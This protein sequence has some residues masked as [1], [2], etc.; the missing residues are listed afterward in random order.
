MTMRRSRRLPIVLVVVSLALLVAALPP[1]PAHAG[2]IKAVA[3]KTGLN[4]PAAFTF[5]PGGLIF[6]GEK[7][8]GQI[9]VLNRT[10]KATRLF[11]QVPNIDGAG[12][13]G[14]LGIALHPKWPRAPFLYAYVTRTLSTGTFNQIIRLRS[15]HGH[16]TRMKVLFQ[17]RLNT[18]TNHNGGRILFGPDRMLY[19]VVGEN[20]VPA[21]SQNRATPL[22]KVLRMNTSG[23][24][25]PGNPFHNRVFS[26]GLRNSFGFDF[27]PLT[28]R[29]WESENGPRCN[30]EVNH[31]VR[32]GNYA[33]GP[34]QRT[35]CLPPLPG[36]LETNL[37]GPQ[38][39]IMPQ[40]SYTPT[41]APT[42]LV[43][44]HRCGLGS[45]NE[46]RMFFG[47]LKRHRIHRVTL[48]PNRLSVKSQTAVFIHRMGILSME[49][50]PRGA[51][52]FSDAT[53]IFK[54]IRR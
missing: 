44:C 11:F 48:T 1:Q 51:I 37:D 36:A 54:L 22:G 21:N 33:W 34:H 42:G 45:A 29:L 19:A 27:E 46:G 5:G 8:T 9:R 24:A 4:F 28:R 39:R 53:G 31:I 38:P 47:D 30:D 15:Q 20:A 50:G 6:Y 3:V 14:L 32:G 26:Y 16:G 35:D 13:R 49:A 18:H 23:A 52:Y 25:A 12:E 7:N 2:S 10:S 43:F 17:V 41:I 40:L